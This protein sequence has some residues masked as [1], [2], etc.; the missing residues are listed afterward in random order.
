M[1][2]ELEPASS[3]W[4]LAL[5]CAVNLTVACSLPPAQKGAKCQ[6]TTQ[7]A[8]GLACVSGRCGNDLSAIAATN[9]VPMLGEAGGAM[10]GSGAVGGTGTVAGSSGN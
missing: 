8:E 1:R 2:L 3:L 4:T 7:C 6:R 5:C 10:G 9:T